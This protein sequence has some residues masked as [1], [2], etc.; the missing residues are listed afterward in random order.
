MYQ[1]P[2][3]AGAAPRASINLGVGDPA[4]G[5]SR[6]LQPGQIALNRA[7]IRIA[8]PGPSMDLLA[9]FEAD[10]SQRNEGPRGYNPGFFGEFPDG[11]VNRVLAVFDQPLR[12]R[13]SAFVAVAPERSP[14]MGEEDTETAR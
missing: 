4:S 7:G 5:T 12:D 14:R 1:H 9:G 11:R 10:R 2:G 13:P 3:L 6:P 8:L